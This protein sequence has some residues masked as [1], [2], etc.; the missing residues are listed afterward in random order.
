MI[1]TS[2]RADSLLTKDT[3]HMKYLDGENIGGL[4][5]FVVIHQIFTLQMSWFYHSNSLQK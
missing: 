4:G 1:D 5:E 3:V 2:I